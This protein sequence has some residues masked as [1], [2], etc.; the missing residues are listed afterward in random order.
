MKFLSCFVW[1]AL[2]LSASNVWAQAAPPKALV[3]VAKL[4]QAEVQAGQRFVGT[5][6]P[7][8]RA[9]IGSAVA[10]RVQQVHVEDGDPVGFVTLADGARK[11]QPL[12]QVLTRTIELEVENARA[13]LELRQQELLELENGARPED[14]EEAR[15]RATKSKALMDYGHAKFKRLQLLFDQGRASS[16]DEVEESQSQ[17]LAMESAY[18]EANAA[19]DRL[20]NG[21]RKEHVAQARARLKAQADEVARLE[22]ILSKYT[23][24]AP[25]DGYVVAKHTE[26]GAWV[27]PGTPV[28][29]VVELDP[30]EIVV[31]VPEAFIARVHESLEA[32]VR[33]EAW[34]EETFSGQV[35]RVVP[36]ADVRSRNFPV[37]LRV[38]NPRGT[39][40]HKL[41]AGML[42]DVV[43]P[44]GKPQ[45]A[46]LAPKD[47]LVLDQGAA[48]VIKI[49]DK[50]LTSPVPVR[51][52]VAHG[53]LIQVLDETH[54]LR[55]GD[56]VVVR[57]NE[58]LPKPG[59]PVQVVRVV[60]TESVA[61]AE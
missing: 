9:V 38:P 5:V 16:R 34:P 29:E 14:I 61:P 43:L 22:D 46:L 8:R 13:L 23:I 18:K 15:A 7:P 36:Q 39:H 57:G 19:Y 6:T 60:P 42:A 4:V 40:G 48:K 11:G 32:H 41:K 49:D 25:F 55:A 33:V 17:S 50:G 58:R 30:V 51:L 12:V 35:W 2:A 28:I 24:R 44:I 26:V 1:L 52:G 56:Q 27:N 37:K 45:L 21:A 59:I 20:V 47:A 53:S 10:G 54:A 3:E 31:S